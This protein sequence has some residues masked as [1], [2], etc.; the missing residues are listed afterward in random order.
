MRMKMALKTT[1]SRGARH[2]QYLELLRVQ[3]LGFDLGETRLLDRIRRHRAEHVLAPVPER[4]DH[5][6]LQ[7]VV[8]DV[9]V[10]TCAAARGEW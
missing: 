9:L 7:L 2:T 10:L 1:G 6:R 8:G 3:E 5:V 4:V